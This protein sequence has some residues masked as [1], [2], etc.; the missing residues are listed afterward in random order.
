[1]KALLIR[2]ITEELLPA[3][4]RQL[5]EALQHSEELKKEQAYLLRT[6]EMVVAAMPPADPGF[7]E[8]VLQGLGK[9]SKEVALIVRI[10]PRVAAACIA[11]IAALSLF[12]YFETGSL[13]TDVLM[14]LDGLSLEEAVALTEY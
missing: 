6:R 8:K 14:G 2:S 5:Q 10:Y 3:E 11:V 1:M 9:S 4:E 7:A 12:L 13:S